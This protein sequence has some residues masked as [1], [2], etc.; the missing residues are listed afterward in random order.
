VLAAVISWS[1]LISY[2]TF[3]IVVSSAYMNVL[4]C[5]RR[6]MSFMYKMKSNG[7]RTEPCGTPYLTVK[8]LDN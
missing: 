4:P 3:I 8:L 7:P 5:V 1:S 2:P 6:G